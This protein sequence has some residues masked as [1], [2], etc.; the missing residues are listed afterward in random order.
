M[1]EFPPTLSDEIKVGGGEG[2]RMLQS[3]G[4]S[5][6]GEGGVGPWLEDTVLLV[7]LLGFVVLKCGRY[8]PIWYDAGS[9]Y[10]INLFLSYVPL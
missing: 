4:F 7:S 5:L 10:L 2:V 6:S 8:L 9:S 1:S 3:G